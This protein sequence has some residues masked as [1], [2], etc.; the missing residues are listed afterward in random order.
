M[1][2]RRAFAV[3]GP[4]AWNSRPDPVRNPDVTEAVSRRL[5]V[6]CCLHCCSPLSASFR[7]FGDDALYKIDI[8]THTDDDDD[9]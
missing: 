5:I 9:V 3:A 7:W 2:S 6:R 1:Y 4:T 8:A